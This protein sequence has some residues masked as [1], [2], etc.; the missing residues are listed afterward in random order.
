MSGFTVSTLD[1]ADYRGH[2]EAAATVNTC[3]LLG[4]AVLALYTMSRPASPV[5]CPPVHRA[6][7]T[8][9]AALATLGQVVSA[10]AASLEL[11][12]VGQQVSQTIGTALGSNVMS[13]KAAQINES[14]KVKV[15][16]AKCAPSNKN[17]YKAMSDAEKRA[18]Q[19]AVEALK[20]ATILFI[21][22]G[23]PHC[24]DA[25]PGFCAKAERDSSSRAYY[26]VNCGCLPESFLDLKDI[27]Y[28]PN[29]K[30]ASDVNGKVSSKVAHFAEEAAP[31]GGSGS[32]MDELFG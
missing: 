28:V 13:A 17:A 27:Q 14:T 10:R 3:L 12:Q 32:F 23:C 6:T 2:E 11:G 20:N 21:S 1:Y 22:H 7:T 31:Q 26:I 19:A 29:E 9:Y 25:I 4:L 24:H 15:I 18:C 16:D 30:D 5:F 8:A